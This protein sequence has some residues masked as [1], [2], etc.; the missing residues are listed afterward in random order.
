MER[1]S[2]TDLPE[3]M[4]AVARGDR[5]APPLPHCPVC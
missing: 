2:L 3:E 5:E 4:R 1:K